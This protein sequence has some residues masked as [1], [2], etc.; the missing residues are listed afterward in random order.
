MLYRLQS[1]FK[2]E[3]PEKIKMCGKLFEGNCPGLF[4]RSIPEF[5]EGTEKSTEENRGNSLCSCVF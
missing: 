5:D 4:R 3:L 1:S 2:V